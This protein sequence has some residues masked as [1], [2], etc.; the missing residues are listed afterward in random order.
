MAVETVI[1]T[2]RHAQTSYGAEHR[3]AGSVDVPLSDRGVRD[4]EQAAK[5]MAIAAQRVDV[6]V[7][8][9]M[10]RS[11]ETARLLGYDPSG[12]IQTDLCNERRFGILEGRTWEE[13]PHIEPPILLIEVGGDMHSVNPRGG[14]P[15][16]DVWQRAKGFRRFVL[17][18]SEGRAVLVV[19]HGVFLQMFHGVL[20]GTSCIESLATYPA[21]LELHTFRLSDGALADEFEPRLLSEAGAGF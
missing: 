9:K 15:F 2:L 18:Q 8:S 1:Y 6:V 19:S 7:T 4:C 13:V 3:Y 21:S 20:R 10:T 12:C 14:E 17:D 11:I 16:E 5:A